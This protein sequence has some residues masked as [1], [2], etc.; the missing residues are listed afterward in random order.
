[1]SDRVALMFDGSIAQIGTPR[2]VYDRPVSRRVADYFGDC[3]YIPGRV[4]AGCF[5]GRG[6]TCPVQASD[7]DYEL[8]LRPA[9]LDT[10]HPGDYSLTVE[11]IAF[12]GGDTLV[13][14][15]GEDTV[16]WKKSCPQT[17]PWKPGD[18]VRGSIQ[19]ANAVLLP[20]LKKE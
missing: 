14:F 12:R 10:D 17:P 6:I 2:Q 13:T 20:V 11:S 3:V 8:M 15:R 1:M 16:V 7:G 9:D 5:T 19:T 18:C 4:T